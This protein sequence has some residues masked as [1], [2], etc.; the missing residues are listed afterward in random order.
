MLLIVILSYALSLLEFYVRCSRL[1]VNQ[2]C[3]CIWITERCIM[4]TKPLMLCNHKFVGKNEKMWIS[5]FL[6]LISRKQKDS[7]SLESANYQLIVP[8]T[9][10]FKSMSASQIL[11]IEHTGWLSTF[12]YSYLTLLHLYNKWRLQ[13]HYHY[14]VITYIIY[15]VY[16]FN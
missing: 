3:I 2:V 12:C 6:W 15:N 10:N 13:S 16:S 4:K 8:L 5:H 11:Q 14:Y 9:L 1:L 7:L